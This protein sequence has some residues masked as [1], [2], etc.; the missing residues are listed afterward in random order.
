MFGYVKIYKPELK[1]KDY[2]LYKGFYCTMCKDIGREY[3]FVLKFLLSYDFVFLTILQ[4]SITDLCP[5]WKRKRCSFNPTVSC[6]ICEYNEKTKFSTSAAIFMI[7]YKIK[8]DLKDSKLLKKIS[9]LFL[10]PF[11]YFARKKA[12]K[13]YPE[14]DSLFY[15]YISK[16]QIVEENKTTN[17]DEAAEPTAIVL[18]RLFSMNAGDDKLKRILETMGYHIGRWIY[19]ADAADDLEK[20]NANNNYNVFIQANVENKNNFDLE[21]ILND[22][23]RILNMSV[24]EAIKAFEVIDFY[25]YRDILE[26]IL[27]LGMPH[28]QKQIINREESRLREKSI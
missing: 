25:H 23:N 6:N 19:L 20:D 7:Y 1:C 27:Y 10:L 21:A 24:G 4:M 2:E 16:Q 5:T 28:I 3:G 8:D 26:N 22:A 11:V 12:M 18:S 13:L 15:D 9:R 17:V 14:M